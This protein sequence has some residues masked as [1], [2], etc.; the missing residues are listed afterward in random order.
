MHMQGRLRYLIGTLIALC[1]VALTAYQGTARESTV[2]GGV[3]RLLNAVTTGSATKGS[4]TMSQC[5]ES[6]IYVQWSAGTDAGVVKIESAHDES[7]TGT[8]ATLATITWSAASKEDVVQI[9]G[10]HAAIK[11][12]VSTT[13]T[14]GTVT[15]WIACN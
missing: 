14:N 5:R 6:V 1:I 10:I 7:Y 8:W 3:D 15:T 2:T 13:V 4:G 11:T 9:T 12:R